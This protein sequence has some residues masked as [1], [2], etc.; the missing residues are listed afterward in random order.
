MSRIKFRERDLPCG[1]QP[2]FLGAVLLL[3]LPPRSPAAD[4]IWT[5]KAERPHWSA[6][7][8]WD[9][10]IQAGDVL[11]F[12]G[13]GHYVENDLDSGLA[14]G[15]LIFESSDWIVHGNALELG[16][17]GVLLDAGNRGANVI[18]DVDLV[19]AD[20]KTVFST[21]HHLA[22]LTVSGRIRGEGGIASTGQR[23]HVFFTNPGNDFQGSVNRS[24]VDDFQFAS[25]DDKGQPCS[26]GAGETVKF[27]S[28]SKLPNRFVYRGVE[29]AE[30]DR[31]FHFRNTTVS[32]Q[33][34]ANSTLIFNGPITFAQSLGFGGRHPIEILGGLSQDGGRAPAS[35][36]VSL[37][38]RNVVTLNS[39]TKHLG[40]TRITGGTLR[41][42][43]NA[44]FAGSP[45]IS[46][47]PAWDRRRNAEVYAALDVSP[48]TT[49]FVVDTAQTLQ[50]G[51]TVRGDVV[52]DGTLRVA[53]R[54]PSSQSETSGKELRTLVFKDGLQLRGSTVLRVDPKTPASDLLQVARILRCGG[55]LNVVTLAENGFVAGQEFQLWVA[56]RFEGRFDRL[57]LPELKSNDLRWDQS[58][59]YTE[60]I[61]AV[62]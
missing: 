25:I 30:T 36:I 58:R 33:A 45:V 9:K 10:Q 20:P 31:T 62:R 42:A 54:G 29:K 7:D 8:N 12:R 13:P 14:L 3:C 11:H 21:T 55:T 37:D 18:V 47:E 2:W 22:R 50:G 32:N 17:A 59:L 44:S 48:R 34:Y 49:P 41:L 27:F 38:E 6:P 26:L 43:E 1:W 28:P 16:K 46:L 5:G 39:P 53:S 24:H 57:V 56:P 52:I 35:L 19:I 40:P 4:V 51:G 23:Q 15:G 60:G 61:V